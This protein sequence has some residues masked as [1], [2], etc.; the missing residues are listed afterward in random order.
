VGKVIT[1]EELPE[2]APG[3]LMLDSLSVGSPD[4]RMRVFRYAP[5]DICVPP[6]DHFLIV[7]YRRGATSM[8]RRV[9][10]AWKREQVG[11]GVASLLTRAE[12]SLWRWEDDIEVSHF[13]ISP[14]F[15]TR[16]ATEAFDCDV[17]AVELHDLLG[18][19]DPTLIW[20]SDQMAREVETGSL[21][22]RLYYD[23]L[24]LQATIHILRKYATLRLKAP[25]AHG[26]L[27][28][29]HIQL[30]EQYVEQNI[31]RNITLEELAAICQCTPVQ[32]A[33]KFHAHYSMRPHAFVLQQKVEQACKHLR[34][35]NLAL[36]E[37]ALLCGF[38]DQSHLN[39][40][41][42]QRLDCTPA[43]YRR[44]VSRR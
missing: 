9:S 17:G 18:V 36:K 24:S 20:I 10:G 8:N 25:C 40:V 41:F 30:I 15:M 37:I 32:F 19:G 22:G 7:V 28:P 3:K 1:I 43:E 4:F 27:R 29:A 35:D 2:Y 44:A 12:P 26:H 21:G 5:S 31:A 11:A 38:A 42:R 13:Y 33:R 23:A 16:I 39:R 14:A 6:T 34:K